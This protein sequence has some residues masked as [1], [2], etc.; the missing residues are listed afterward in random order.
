MGKIRIVEAD[1]TH[2][3]PYLGCKK[4]LSFQTERTYNTNVAQNPCYH[5][6]VLC[7]EDVQD[8]ALL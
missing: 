8:F 2:D 6:I 3:R 5:A 7:S 1:E 4:E